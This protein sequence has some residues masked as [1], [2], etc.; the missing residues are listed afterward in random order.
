MKVGLDASGKML[1]SAGCRIDGYF[2]DP[3]LRLF[4]LQ[5]IMIV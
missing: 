4:L 3:T 2:Q 1:Y 5:N